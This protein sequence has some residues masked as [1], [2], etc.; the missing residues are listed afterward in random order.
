[1]RQVWKRQLGP[2]LEESAPRQAEEGI[3][4]RISPGGALWRELDVPHWAWESQIAFHASSSF[5]FNIAKFCFVD[6][7]GP[8]WDG[9]RRIP[10]PGSSNLVHRDGRREHRCRVDGGSKDQWQLDAY[11]WRPWIPSNT[12]AVQDGRGSAPYHIVKTKGARGEG[13]GRLGSG[14]APL[15]NDQDTSHSGSLP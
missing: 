13:K 2:S 8:T 14:A 7:I 11:E 3:D 9:R 15:E 4:S 6:W 5:F 12:R 1:M 10:T